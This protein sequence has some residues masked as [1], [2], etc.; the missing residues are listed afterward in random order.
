MQE[1]Y[2][3]RKEGAL[4]ASLSPH[5][6]L[7]YYGNAYSE[8]GQDGI[9]RRIFEACGIE[10]GRFVEFGAWDGCWLSNSRAL[11][12][13]G[14][15]GVFIECDEQRF[16]GLRAELPPGS[17]AI[18]DRVGTGDG[19]V[20]GRSLDEI[21]RSHGVDPDGV[22]FLSI[23]V[24]GNDLE[25]FDGLGFRPSVILLEGGFNYN[26]AITQRVDMGYA[27]KNNQHPLGAVVDT[28]QA[29]GYRAV[30]FFQDTYLVRED[31]AHHFS[32]QISLGAVGMY[33]DAWAFACD[34]L[35]QLLLDLRGRDAYLREFETKALGSFEVHP[36]GAG[37]R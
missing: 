12:L 21:L 26:P 37:A 5:S 35:R 32:E 25:I 4:S 13:R 19:R 6:L 29:R 10:S 1:N 36:L 3:L 24:D 15:Q 20:A 14:W 18:N 34:A 22:D 16:Q 7:R 9:L 23:D 17:M 27:A 8:C 30:C 31:Q 33:R 2:A 28:A 11:T